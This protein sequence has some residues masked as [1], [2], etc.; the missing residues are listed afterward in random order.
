MD[1]DESKLPPSVDLGLLRV[2]SIVV[3]I[4]LVP[5]EVASQLSY[6]IRVLLGILIGADDVVAADVHILFLGGEDEG[7]S[8][9]I[10]EG[11]DWV[12]GAFQCPLDHNEGREFMVD[13][14]YVP[15][16]VLV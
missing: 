2:V 8:G 11:V 6:K 14:K 7:A 5:I 1:F 13:G 10:V 3:N 16:Y 9:V 12:A 4:K 15:V